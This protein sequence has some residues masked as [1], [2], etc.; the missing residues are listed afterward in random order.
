MSWKPI[1][2][3]VNASPTLKP[4]QNKVCVANVSV[5]SAKKN[6]GTFPMKFKNKA[7]CIQ[8][9]IVVIPT[10]TGPRQKKQQETRIYRAAIWQRLRT[11]G[12]RSCVQE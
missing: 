7:I 6:K 9:S 11:S 1:G 2:V 12:I 3:S 5:Q 8:F 4:E 10:G